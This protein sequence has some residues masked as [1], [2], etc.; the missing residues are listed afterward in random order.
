MFKVIT[1]RAFRSHQIRF[2]SSSPVYLVDCTRTPIGSYKGQLKNFKSTELGTIAVRSLLDRTKV[3]ED[4]INCLYFGNVIQANA[5]QAPAR[6]VALNAGLTLKTI[7][8]TINKVCAS[9][10]KSIMF[11]SQHIMLNPDDVLIAGGMESMSQVPYYLKREELP[12]GGVNLIDGL[13]KDGL[14]DAF[15]PIHMGNC[16]E[17]TSKKLNI[18]RKQQD[19]FA[20]LSYQRAIKATDAKLLSKEIT[21]VTI[22]GKRGKADIVMSEDEEIR[23]VNFEKFSS[24][25]TVFDKANGTITAANASKLSDGASACLLMSEKML[26]ELNL[27]PLARIDGFEDSGVAPIDFPIAPADAIKKLLK[28]ANLTKD[29]INRWE[30]NEAFSCVVL[31]NEKLLGLNPDLININGGAVSL[32][33]PIGMSGARIVGSLAHHLKKGERGLASICNGGGESSAILITKLG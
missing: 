10:M 29:D 21:P 33:H 4:R 31:A 26:K 23:R 19:D 9:G 3:P 20:T 17:N 13:L 8:T 32:G 22:K 25:P 1:K 11:A 12:Y 14:T 15:D 16:G 27:E 28:K 5:G 7:T 30:I 18:T 24:L 6:Q 2:N